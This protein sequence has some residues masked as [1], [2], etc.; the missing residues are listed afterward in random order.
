VMAGKT[1]S[2]FSTGNQISY[3]FPKNWP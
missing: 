3:L 2:D 1:F